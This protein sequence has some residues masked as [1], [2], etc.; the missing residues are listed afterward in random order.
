MFSK[1][2]VLVLFCLQ[3]VS[4]AFSQS[5]KPSDL[6]VFTIAK[7]PVTADEFIYLYKKNHQNKKDEFT[8]AKVEEYLDL[9]INFK[10]KVM[11][12]QSRGIDTTQVFK[13]EYN[14]YKDELRK[15]YL[16]DSKL[17]D[18]L[19]RLTYARMKEEI[20][21]SHIL[22]NL[23]EN[24][25][26]EDTARAYNK[27][28]DL[29]TRA[30]NGEDFGALAM[31]NSEDPSAKM[32]KGNLGYFSALQMVFQFENAAYKTPVGQ[33]SMPERSRFGYHILKVHDRRPARGEV[34]V[35][36]IMIRT[37]ENKDNAKSKNTIFEVYDEL[38][39]GVDWNELCKQYSEDL[40]SK[41][42]GGK[43]RPFGSGM[44]PA[45]PE[46]ERVA[47]ELQKP[48]E[49]SD[50][51]QT[52]FGW[53]IIR[54]ERKIPLGSYEELAASLKNKV[55]R[56]ERV[57]V[58]K[59][60]VY[61]KMKKENHFTEYA[62]AKAKLIALADTSLTKGNWTPA[63]TDA[64]E[65]VLF[66]LDNKPT[67]VSEFIDYMLKN[68]HPTGQDPVVFLN[69]AYN[70]YVEA[71]LVD[72]LEQQ[73][74][75]KTPE[76]KWLLKEYYE[77]ILL[78]DIMEKEVW[79]KASEDSVGQ[80]NYFNEN[81]AAFKADER[82]NAV[83]YSSTTEDHTKALMPYLEKN[84]TAKVRELVASYKIR[85]ESGAYEKEDRM[86]LSKIEWKPGVYTEKN[87]NLFYVIKVTGILPPG[88]KTF[89]EARPEVI[90]DYQTYLEK[91]WVAQLKKKYPVKVN[92]KGK[93][94]VFSR[95]VNE[96]GIQ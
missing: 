11:E 49:I 61:D 96:T 23:K 91:K 69:Q 6:A 71:K 64:G 57:Q 43:L 67:Y 40:S 33:V 80:R 86:V 25:T 35:S 88:N 52:Q 19:V 66:K 38:Q 93:D 37:G 5:S 60:A 87:N 32:N 14:T 59:Q 83:L 22:I 26:P 45:V 9:F 39:K 63:F 78:F 81:S 53:H 75:Q 77:G 74:I 85:E 51:V 58:S 72:L 70:A 41:D 1:K 8:T 62:D 12:A 82:V 42:N 65:T 34:E 29:R 21:A 84:D 56:D 89:D 55:S 27:I 54:L 10:L 30:M 79:N 90:S 94:L 7:K 3:V 31:A 20:N 4:S 46:F 44:M 76:Y 36:H 73:I 28:M 2:L 13:N 95:L 18:S 48:G 24:P 16:P 92:K 68:Q 15:P 47:L 50:P 17:L